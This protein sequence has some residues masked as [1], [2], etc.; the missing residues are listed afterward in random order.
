MGV[1]QDLRVFARECKGL[2]HELNCEY[3]R[4]RCGRRGEPEGE[5]EAAC[6]GTTRKAKRQNV[7]AAG[8]RC[9]GV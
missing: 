5:E 2:G 6:Q 7:L 9:M 1:Q 8:E 4:M 3:M